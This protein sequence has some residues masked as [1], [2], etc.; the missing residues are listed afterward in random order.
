MVK[1]ATKPYSL[2][3]TVM[4][5]VVTKEK[6]VIRYVLES[7]ILAGDK[8]IIFSH[9]VGPLKRLKM[10][11]ETRARMLKQNESGVLL[12]TGD[13]DIDERARIT[14]RAREDPSIHSLLITIDTGGQSNDLAFANHVLL[15]DPWYNPADED[16][17]MDRVGGLMQKK[18]IHVV[19]FMIRGAVDVRLILFF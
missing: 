5:P 18:E 6:R 7:V 12:I 15:L 3:D 16:Q 1:H 2:G 17:A 13:D 8:C 11:F 19:R 14:A 10:L 4:P 9:W